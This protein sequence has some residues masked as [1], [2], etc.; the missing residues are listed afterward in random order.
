MKSR[1]NY[2]TRL[3]ILISLTLIIEMVGLPQP[4]TGPLVNMML[5]LTTLLLDIKAGVILGCISPLVAAVRGQLPPFLIPMVPFIIAGNILLVVLF[6]LIGQVG[7]SS[8]PAL[9]NPMYSF[10]VWLGV[11]VSA[12]VKLIWLYTSAK[13]LLPV[14]FGKHLPPQLVA[15]MAMPQLITAISGGI[16]AVIIAG[17][18]KKRA[19]GK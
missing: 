13:L 12:A 2:Y 19:G 10:T 9:A 3:V 14:L 16:L 6:G 15:M 8:R 18:L 5:Y 11:L 4:A 1:T 7:K 17:M